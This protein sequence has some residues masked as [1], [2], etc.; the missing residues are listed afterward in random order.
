[1]SPSLKR[2]H[3]PPS[4]PPKKNTHEQKATIKD[5]AGARKANYSIPAK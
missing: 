5:T 2:G 4:P 3:N 1:M